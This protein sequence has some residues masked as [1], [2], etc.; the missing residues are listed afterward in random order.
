[1]LRSPQVSG[2]LLTPLL[3][4]LSV[5]FFIFGAASKLIHQRA[6]PFFHYHLVVWGRRRFSALPQYRGAIPDVEFLDSLLQHVRNSSVLFRHTRR[7]GL[8]PKL[9]GVAKPLFHE[10]SVTSQLSA[11]SPGHIVSHSAPSGSL[12]PVRAKYQLGHQSFA[13]GVGR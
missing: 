7:R 8:R 3:H 4:R 6:E 5:V 11:R 9:F 10:W 12:N 13:K 2:D 1:M